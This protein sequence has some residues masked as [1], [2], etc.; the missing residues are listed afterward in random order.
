MRGEIGVDSMPGVGSTFGF[1]ATFGGHSAPPALTPLE[2]TAF[3]GRSVL[4]VQ[5]NPVAAQAT[6]RMLRAWSL[7]PLVF[8]TRRAALS[9]ARLAARHGAAYPALLIDASLWTA[10]DASG[11]DSPADLPATTTV[12][13]LGEIQARGGLNDGLE[14]LTAVR[15]PLRSADLRRAILVGFGAAPT[16]ERER[17]PAAPTSAARVLN[18]LVAED[19]PINQKLARRILERRGHRVT[20]VADGMQ[21]V[22]AA[23][24]QDFDVILMDVQMPVLD[25][26][27][28]TQAIRRAQES[29]GR[30][31]PIVALTA[32]ALKGERER[33][34]ASGMDDYL[35]KPF[36]P[37]EL[38]RMVERH[39]PSGG[40]V[41]E[42]GAFAAGAPADAATTTVDPVYDHAK[43]LA[44][45]LGDS[46]F[47]AEMVQALAADLPESL[48]ELAALVQDG[49]MSAAAHAAHRLK[50]AVGN[51]HAA[52]SIRAA[53]RLEAACNASDR[54]AASTAL[55]ELESQV[56]RLLHALASGPARE[57]A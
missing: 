3:A 46:A 33:L 26:V 39:G 45:A 25:G 51:F 14:Q 24:T 27:A 37:D 9:A 19:H 42:A 13:L 47:L 4:L 1:T 12:I 56:E 57:A 35:A 53:V 54:D 5:D 21:A 44:G 38:V 52:A 2:A 10:L 32:H 16:P 43:A 15:K 18:I 49:D 30:H 23:A 50:G 40:A 48:R 31:I 8:P 11:S 17:R 36:D 29:S 20:L 28:A 7:Q 41:H 34:Q 55:R 22:N 6:A